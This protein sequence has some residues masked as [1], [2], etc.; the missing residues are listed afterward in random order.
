M[1][2]ALKT[3]TEKLA[4]KRKASGALLFSLCPL[5]VLFPNTVI[6]Q[7]AFESR[8]KPTCY[9]QILNERRPHPS[10]RVLMPNAKARASNEHM[11]SASAS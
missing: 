8:S 7:V 3:A 11:F 5:R 10:G 9:T 4:H 6:S 2:Q 1:T